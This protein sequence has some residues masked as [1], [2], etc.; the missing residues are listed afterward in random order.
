MHQEQFALTQDWLANYQANSIYLSNLK[1]I[2]L[3]VGERNKLR[4]QWNQAIIWPM[5]FLVIL[6][7]GLMLPLIINVL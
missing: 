5:I 6:M 4:S 3:D 1:Y 2:A 7:L